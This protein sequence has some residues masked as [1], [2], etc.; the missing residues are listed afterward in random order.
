[1]R[2]RRAPG[3]NFRRKMLRITVA[4][5]KRSVTMVMGGTPVFRIVL[6]AT[7]ERPQKRT[8]PQMASSAGAREGA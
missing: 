4:T 6:D 5:T 7:K 2:R 1:M 8:V 3:S